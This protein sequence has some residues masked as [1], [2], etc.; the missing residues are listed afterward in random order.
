MHGI[1]MIG[2]SAAAIVC[3]ILASAHTTAD[4]EVIDKVA[5]G[6][7][8]NVIEGV[9]GSSYLLDGYVSYVESR[10]GACGP[11]AVLVVGVKD[12]VD[13]GGKR[14]GYGSIVVV[15]GTTAA[16]TFRL[17]RPADKIVTT[18]DVKVFGKKYTKGAFDVPANGKIGP[19][20]SAPEKKG[21]IKKS[22]L[23]E[24]KR[25]LSGNNE[26]RVRNPNTFSVAAGLRAGDK[27]KDFE[28]P[29]NGVKSVYVPDGKYDIYFVYS[30][31]PDNL[32]QGDSFTLNGN[33][34][35]IQ[36]VQVVNGNYDIRQVR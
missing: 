15:E 20:S 2:L 12:G 33:G 28:V 23:P 30:D 36:I 16:A 29:A 1:R 7:S 26:V 13:L 27:G 14:F 3:V 9:N 8:F 4:A 11:G 32:F 25:E 17:A 21:K 5:F 24:F 31:K 35:E 19:L 34:V 18:Q 22:P 10:S 6:Q